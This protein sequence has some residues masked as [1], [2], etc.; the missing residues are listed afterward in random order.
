M[1]SKTTGALNY[2]EDGLGNGSYDLHSYCCR[3]DI[4][5]QML[6]G[7]IQQRKF[8]ASGLLQLFR[9]PQAYSHIRQ[10]NLRL[11]ILWGEV[12]IAV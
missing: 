4:R 1:T 11:P 9:R 8:S 10:R 12:L 6:W 5:L 2:E 7:E 3:R